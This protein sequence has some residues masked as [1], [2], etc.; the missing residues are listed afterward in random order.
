[1]NNVERMF[2]LTKLESEA[3]LSLNEDANL[4]KNWPSKGEVEFKDVY[5]K[6]ENALSLS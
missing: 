3:Q 4:S 5:L 6:Y 1:M 2:V